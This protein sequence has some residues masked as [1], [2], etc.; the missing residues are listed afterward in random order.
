MY[1]KQKCPSCKTEAEFVYVQVGH[2]HCC[3]KCNYEFRLEKPRFN[4]LPYLVTLGVLAL[5]GGLGFFVVKTFHDWW[6][7]R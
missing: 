1:L 4:L 7:Y 5:V 2:T 3:K 6:I